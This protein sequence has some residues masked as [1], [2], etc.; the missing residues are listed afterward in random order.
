MG[1]AIRQE[2]NNARGADEGNDR[3]KRAQDAE[4]RAPIAKENERAEDRFGRCEEVACA[5]DAE[6][7]EHQKT[8]GLWLIKGTSISTV[9]WLHFW[10]LKA[11]N[12][13]TIAPRIK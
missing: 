9:Y 6:N 12:V 3:P 4:P 11:K 10:M 1:P 5:P 8:T 7:W 2:R 13:K